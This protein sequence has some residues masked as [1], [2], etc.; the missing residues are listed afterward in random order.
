MSHLELYELCKDATLDINSW[1]KK[2]KCNCMDWTYCACISIIYSTA[3]E[4]IK[5]LLEN[6][7]IEW[8]IILEHAF[9]NDPTLVLTLLDQIPDSII[10]WSNEKVV[11]LCWI[12][13]RDVQSVS[14]TSFK[15][16]IDQYTQYMKQETISD[17]L[18]RL[19]Y[20]LQV[21][22]IDRQ[23]WHIHAAVDRRLAYLFTKCTEWTVITSHVKLLCSLS[24]ISA[25]QTLLNC[26]SFDVNR[27]FYRCGFFQ[28]CIDRDDVAVVRTLLQNKDIF[29][30]YED[31]ISN[32][33]QRHSPIIRS[34]AMREL[35]C[36]LLA[37]CVVRN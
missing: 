27:V 30:F 28:E 12:A 29:Q 23:H 25:L 20:E 17:R 5:I 8:K 32:L 4:N 3:K 24:Y 15:L 10:W 19:L 26:V 18:S 36:R 14:F 1:F 35:F 11:E 34:T 9:Y 37:L 2:R 7:S 33:L 31:V 6:G 13:C 21:V 16:L 22:P